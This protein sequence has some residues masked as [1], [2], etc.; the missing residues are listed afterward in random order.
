MYLPRDAAQA[1]EKMVTFDTARK[2]SWRPSRVLRTPSPPRHG[3][4]D[5]HDTGASTIAVT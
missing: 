2:K 1:S 3:A 4:F 5:A